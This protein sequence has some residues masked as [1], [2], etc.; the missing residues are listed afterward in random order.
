MITTTPH[1]GSPA[2]TAFWVERWQTGR[3]GWDQGGPHHALDALLATAREL[4]LVEPAAMV[5]EPGAGRAHNGAALA[6]QGFAVTSFDAVQ[7][8]VNAA[9]ALYGRVP[10][11]TLTVHN[12]L[13]VNDAWLGRF[14]VVFDRSEE[15]TSELQSH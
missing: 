14:V 9:S 10:G 13:Q 5:L 15:H 8:A 4:G 7:E 11:L 12:A 3:T 6:K 2:S 1:A